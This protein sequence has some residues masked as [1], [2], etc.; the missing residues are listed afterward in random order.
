MEISV[1][2]PS[3]NRLAALCQA[4]RSLQDQSFGD[5]EILVVDN[6]ADS[7]VERKIAEMNDSARVPA[8]YLA[9]RALGLHFARHAGARVAQ[10][11]LL[12][13]TDDD[14]T[15]DPGW[16]QAYADAFACHPQ[17]AVA[18]G[19][20]R[21]VWE[22]APPLWFRQFMD[23]SL[24]GILS[25][26]E[27]YEEFHMGPELF[28]WGVNMAIRREALFAVRGFNPESFGD[29]WLGDGESGLNAKLRERGMAIGYIPQA[30]VHHHIPSGRMTVDYV[31]HRLANQEA[32]ELYTAYHRHIPHRLR[33]AKHALAVAVKN[34]KCFIA[35][36][37]AKGRTDTRSLNVQ[38]QAARAWA[39]LKYVVRLIGDGQFR[40]LVG[41]EDWLVE[42]SDAVAVIP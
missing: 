11:E 21:P 12:V 17:M 36:W 3:Y 30:L 13:F 7:Q 8:R 25:L 20:V 33:L 15:F 23:G 41:K 16:L 22:A 24:C 28:F 40:E 4:V 2:I 31:C 34:S 39:R 18:G 5:F 32:C 37:L 6:A 42:S 35:A 29:I 19:P 10:G 26:M 27:P 38:I 14:A 1:I 9:E